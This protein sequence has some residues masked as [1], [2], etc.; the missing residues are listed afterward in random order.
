MGLQLVAGFSGDDRERGNEG[1]ATRERETSVIA[2]AMVGRR[3]DKAEYGRG[4][5]LRLWR[6]GRGERGN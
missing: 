1:G 4:R 6:K 3:R 5:L 2:A